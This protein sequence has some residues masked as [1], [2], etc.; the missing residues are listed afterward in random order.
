MNP[1]LHREI[2]K[3]S[4]VVRIIHLENGD[5]SAPASCIDALETS[6]EFDHVRP[7]CHRQE[8]DWLVLVQIEHGHQ[9]VPLTLKESPVMFRVERHSVVPWPP[10]DGIPTHDFVRYGID[11]L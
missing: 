10:S 7:A 9:L 3:L 1:L 5:R 11:H 8:G 6:I 4:I 2:L